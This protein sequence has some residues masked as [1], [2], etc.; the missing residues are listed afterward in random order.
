MRVI[1]S[2]YS[3]AIILCECFC[4]TFGSGASGIALDNTEYAVFRAHPIKE[5]IVN[6]GMLTETVLNWCSPATAP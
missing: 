6:E 2:Y 5:H 3:W 4:E 1:V